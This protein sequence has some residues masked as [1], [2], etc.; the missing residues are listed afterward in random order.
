MNL[1]KSNLRTPYPVFDR[2]KARAQQMGIGHE[3][4]ARIIIET[5]LPVYEAETPEDLKKALA[6]QQVLAKLRVS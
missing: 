4:L 3:Q 1:R 6:A 5:S 2:L